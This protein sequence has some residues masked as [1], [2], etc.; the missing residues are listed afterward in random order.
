[1]ALENA[2]SRTAAGFQS[3]SSAEE[4]L[5]IGSVVAAR[6]LDIPIFKDKTSKKNH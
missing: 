1:M 2:Y 5:K 6:I 4:G 3:R